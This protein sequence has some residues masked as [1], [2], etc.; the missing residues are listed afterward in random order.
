MPSELHVDLGPVLV[1][2]APGPTID[3]IRFLAIEADRLRADGF[4]LE[5]RS[6]HDV[7]LI[8]DAPHE[9]GPLLTL[10]AIGLFVAGLGLIGLDLRIE[11]ST[12]VFYR[13]FRLVDSPLLPVRVHEGSV[14]RLCKGDEG[15]TAS[16]RP[17]SCDL[18]SGRVC[19]LARVA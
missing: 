14:A 18:I 10:A 16:D 9:G 2:S 15:R 1:S 4:V 3:P 12:T 8:H 11:A 13:A 5:Y 7:Y 17:P 6:Y 19:W